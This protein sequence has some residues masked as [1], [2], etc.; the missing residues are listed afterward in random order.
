MTEWWD[1]LIEEY[2]SLA[3]Q[4]SLDNI[5][6]GITNLN[7]IDVGVAMLCVVPVALVLIIKIIRNRKETA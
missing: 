6:D 2:H 5:D 3:I 7:N 4:P 1:E